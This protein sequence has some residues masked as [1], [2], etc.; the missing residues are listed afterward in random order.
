MSRYVFKMFYLF[1]GNNHRIRA[2]HPLLI[3]VVL[4]GGECTGCYAKNG[5]R[6]SRQKCD[7]IFVEPSVPSQMAKT[8]PSSET[9]LLVHLMVAVCIHAATFGSHNF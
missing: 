3:M 2:Y 9:W 7:C 8:R 1:V 4:L 5:L 6:Y